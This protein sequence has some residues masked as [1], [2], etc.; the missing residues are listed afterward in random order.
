MSAGSPTFSAPEPGAPLAKRPLATMCVQPWLAL[1]HAV[2]APAAVQEMAEPHFAQNIVVLV[3]RRS[4]D[5]ERDAAAAPDRLADRRD[6][7]AQMQ[8]GARIGGDD[9][10]GARDDVE[11]VRARI[12]AMG[13]RQALGQQAE[14]VEMRQQAVGI[15]GVGEGALIDRL[16][17][18]HVDAPAGLAP[19]LAR[20]RASSSSEHHCGPFGPNWTVKVGLST[21]AAIAS[22][23]A[24][25]SAALGM[26]AER[27][28][29]STT[30]ARL[31][32]HRVEHRLGGAV[33][34]RIAVAHGRS[35]A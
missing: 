26:G 22:T 32:G 7:G 18:M 10:A 20:W 17:Q 29:A 12:D 19:R 27:N 13:E 23:R 3:E 8:V 24:T 2:E 4:V 16:Q 34:Q 1:D 14:L 28:C 21:A 35:R 33:D 31:G 30:R 6:A 11:F 15:G 9:G 25:C 5:A